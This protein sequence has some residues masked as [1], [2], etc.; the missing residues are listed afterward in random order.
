MKSLN[1]EILSDNEIV[2]G[3][4]AC[5]EL[6]IRCLNKLFHVLFFF[7]CVTVV[8]SQG[9]KQFRRHIIVLYDNSGSF[10]NTNYTSQID[11]INHKLIDLFNNR[12]IDSR[13]NNL[14][15]EKENG[16]DF[17]DPAMDEVSFFWFVAKRQDNLYFLSSS[18][19]D[20][21]NLLQKFARKYFSVGI[22]ST[23]STSN[24]NISKYVDSNVKIRPDY[25]FSYL[26]E[27]YNRL[28]NAT[29]SWM[30]DYSFTAYTY[31]IIWDVLQT[32]YSKEYII[33]IVS[34]FLSG[35]DFGNKQ[36]ETKFRSVYNAGGKDLAT[37]MLE[38]IDVLQ[39]KFFKIDYFDYSIATGYQSNNNPVILGILAFKLRPN[40][41]YPEVEKT[42]LMLNSN[43]HFTQKNF[44]SDIYNIEPVTVSFG[45]NKQL[46]VNKI[47]TLIFD[48]DSVIASTNISNDTIRFDSVT[49]NYTLPTTEIQIKNHRTKQD[50]TSNNYSI[51]Y[52]FYTDYDLGESTFIK[53][54]HEVNRNLDVNNFE[55]LTQ[56][57]LKQKI[58]MTVFIFLLII[59]LVFYIIRMLG[60]P[61]GILLRMATFTDNYESADFSENGKGKILTD[62]MNW[63]ETEEDNK[64]FKIKISG[65]FS[66][67]YS[68][69]FFN[70]KEQTGFPVS[71]TPN[72]LIAPNGFAVHVECGI[73]FTNSSEHPVNFDKAFKKGE[74]EFYIVYKKEEDIKVTEPQYFSF[75]IEVGSINGGIQ[76]FSCS[77]HK[78]YDFH[79][80]P[81]LGS[82]WVGIDPGTTGSCIASATNNEDLVIEQRN[83]EDR[84]IPSEI[85]IDPGKIKQQ[86]EDQIR[87]ACYFGERAAASKDEKFIRFISMKK[88]I[89]YADKFIL[90]DSIELDSKLLSSLLIEYLYTEHKKYISK[91]RQTHSQF[92]EN[93]GKYAPQRLA[94]AIPN[95]FTATKIQHL[96]DSIEEIPNSP[97]KEIRFIYE[98]EAILVNY[99]NQSNANEKKQMSESG[100][101]VFVYDMGGATINATLANIKR[102]QKNDKKE[103][104]ITIISKL[105]YGIGGDT[106]DYAFIKWIYSKKDS[107]PQLSSTDPF[108]S[109]NMN[110]RDRQDLKKAILQ[111][112]IDSVKNSREEEG[113]NLLNRDYIANK[114]NRLELTKKVDENGYLTNNDPFYKQCLNGPESF[115]HDPIFKE[116]IWDNIESIVSDIMSI[117]ANKG[118]ISLD[119]VIM[120]GRSS[121][122]PMVKET[123]EKT[124][125]AKSKYKPK[126]IQLSMAESKS[127]VAK[128]ACYFGTQKKSIILRNRTTN[129]VFGV[130]QKFLPAESAHF[131]RLINAGVDFSEK[132]TVDNSV[133]VTKQKDFG[134]DGYKVRFCQVMGVN[135]EQIIANNERHKFSDIAI[136]PAKPVAIERVSMEITDKDK[137]FCTTWNTNGDAI[138][139]EARVSDAEITKCNDEHYTFFI[140]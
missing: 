88:L 113:T 101:T 63:T 18:K 102:I 132:G 22:N 99:I 43:I 76:K 7:L 68:N 108:I 135:P 134:W 133:S 27:S 36:D 117:C 6:V 49:L 127:A 58:I 122:F 118:I 105:G 59:F 123:V 2:S 56:L 47:N 82:V 21:Q 62:Y 11:V 73:S 5:D 103:F 50:F 57:S 34:D 39:N 8:N 44:E 74:F 9:N 115:L 125:S 96:K 41:G 124:I 1:T 13:F 84:I 64:Q 106:I 89:G 85:V 23:Y 77:K 112:K 78:R 45:H 40:T 116:Y 126:F 3:L 61:T 15:I 72:S 51:K 10:H 83:G 71:I 114:L 86:S 32:N 37:P 75:D 38:R 54:T 87:E 65:K 53:Y 31:P 136:L 98:A 30:G 110:I 70:W 121:L 95:N 12:L 66:Y 81:E 137:I 107:Y 93:N 130:I 52:V 48:G 33:I 129:G 67:R 42:N 20:D 25:K 119:T 24:E 131:H 111:L 19:S 109:G 69:K 79:V 28:H 17:F 55:F 138:R 94:V 14:S 90:K 35:S 80:G 97:F 91:L 60:K 139:K 4:L 46:L 104:H 140:K 128:G 26:D 92:F 29:K 16:I 100:E 120:S